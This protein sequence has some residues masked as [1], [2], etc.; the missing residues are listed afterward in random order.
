MLPTIRNRKEA[1]SVFDDFFNKDFLSDFFTAER[2][3]PAVNVSEEKD[4]YKIEVAAPG[5]KKKD[6]NV[7]LEDNILTISSEKQDE[8]EEKDKNYM[9]KEFYYSSF[10]RSFTLPENV[11]AEDIKATHSDGVLTVEV[12]KKEESKAKPSKQIE[13]K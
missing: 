4:K 13:I 12:P 6:F 1:P 5:L 3:T 8:D 7:N 2:N 11:K 10:S 9:R